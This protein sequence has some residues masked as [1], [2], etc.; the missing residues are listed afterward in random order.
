M[1]II[2]V[3]V[4]SE[5][6]WTRAVVA[7]GSDADADDWIHSGDPNKAWRR[8]GAPTYDKIGE[9][10]TADNAGR[11]LRYFPC[12]EENIDG[13]WIKVTNGYLTTDENA[14]EA[15]RKNKTIPD[16]HEQ[17]P[18]VTDQGKRSLVFKVKFK[19][20]DR[21][22]VPE[23]SERLHVLRFD[24]KKIV[25]VTDVYF[26]VKDQVSLQAPNKKEYA[27][28]YEKSF[29]PSADK[30]SDQ[31]QELDDNGKCVK[32]LLALCEHYLKGFISKNHSV[33]IEDLQKQ[34]NRQSPDLKSILKLLIDYQMMIAEQMLAAWI[35]SPPKK[36]NFA[37]LVEVAVA[38]VAPRVA[39]MEKLQSLKE[40]EPVPVT[41]VAVPVPPKA[42]VPPKSNTA[43][44]EDDEDI[45]TAKPKSKD[46]DVD[47]LI[48]AANAN[49]SPSS[50]SGV[51]K[52]T[53][54]SG[55]SATTNRSRRGLFDSDADADGA[56]FTSNLGKKALGT[57]A[58]YDP[59]FASRATSTLPPSMRVEADPSGE[60]DIFSPVAGARP[61]TPKP[62]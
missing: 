7:E 17:G 50:Y 30:T 5:V 22:K 14:I 53:S 16:Q 52:M 27:D 39:K 19:V 9:K 58:Q 3:Y 56:T 12:S 25:D 59:V 54:G 43:M 55:F 61:T 15:L 60:A 35:L 2:T 28:I 18:K 40:P 6:N 20:S 24:V 44:A 36:E 46:D 34:L 1:P 23:A 13:N 29:N 26:D 48:A 49:A 62:T 42:A 32:A 4:I 8:Y 41:I 51:A 21:R 10:L 38:E 57:K 37:A 31:K 47:A 33:E 45:F 11:L